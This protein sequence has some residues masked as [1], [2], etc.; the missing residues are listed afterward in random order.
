MRFLDAN[1]IVY[2][3]IQIGRK[4]DAKTSQIKNSAHH[5][6]GRVSKG[7]KVV[8][9]TVHIS[10]TANILE[11]IIGIEDSYLPISDLLKA[12]N[13]A[14]ESVDKNLYATG[15]DE[16]KELK[17]GVND[18]LA[19]IVMKNLGISEIYSFD[20]HFDEIEGIKRVEK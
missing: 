11:E 18:G 16:A 17:V 6:I 9:T 3:Q 14:I 19:V 4:L 12:E 2:D 13:I 15:L 20:G 10:E 7:E 5:I 8:T 1:V